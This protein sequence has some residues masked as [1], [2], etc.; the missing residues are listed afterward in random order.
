MKKF[1]GASVLVLVLAMSAAAHADGEKWL[2]NVSTVEQ[3]VEPELWVEGPVATEADCLEQGKRMAFGMLKMEDKPAKMKVK[4][5][6]LH[7]EKPELEKV[8]SCEMERR[9]DMV[10]DGKRFDRLAA[11]I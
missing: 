7:V 3:G 9:Y 4:L 11:A 6:C 2:V 5:Q 10:C 8:I 1:F